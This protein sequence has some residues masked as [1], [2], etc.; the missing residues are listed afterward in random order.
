MQLTE[1]HGVA[2]IEDDEGQWIYDSNE[3]RALPLSHASLSRC[4]GEGRRYESGGAVRAYRFAPGRKAREA[5]RKAM[6]VY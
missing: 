6:R 4:M 1:C 3:S 2:T 5:M